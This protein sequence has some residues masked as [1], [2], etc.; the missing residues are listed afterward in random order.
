MGRYE[1]KKTTSLSISG[2]TI[3]NWRQFVKTSLKIYSQ[4]LL[5]ALK[6]KV[7]YKSL[8]TTI[9]SNLAIL[10]FNSMEISFIRRKKKEFSLMHFNMRSLP[11]NLTSL[12]EI[13]WTI[14]GSPEII[15]TSETKLQRKKH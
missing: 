8:H 10:P 15:A 5:L 7:N 9:T 11:K 12:E 3:K 14:K 6:E 4:I 13:I 2:Q 1:G